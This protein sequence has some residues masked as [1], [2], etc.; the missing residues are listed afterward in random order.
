MGKYLLRSVWLFVYAMTKGEPPTWRNLSHYLSQSFAA[1]RMSAFSFFLL[2]ATRALLLV[3]LQ[4]LIIKD[5][6]VALHPLDYLLPVK[7]LHSSFSFLL[8]GGV[9]ELQVE[10]L[11]SSTQYYF[12]VG[13]ATKLCPYPDVVA[14]DNHNIKIG[15]VAV[16]SHTYK[17]EIFKMAFILSFIIAVI[18][19]AVVLMIVSRLNLGLSVANFTSAIIAALVIALV[20]AVVNWLLGALGIGFGGGLLGL[21]I[22]LI[23]AAIVLMVSDRFVAGMRVNGFGGA[24]IAAIAIAVVNWLVTLLLAQLGLVV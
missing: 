2:I 5:L 15:T 18:V 14:H 1:I 12:V 6:H 23:V 16:H 11:Y 8:P 20:N 10:V 3:R 19:A 7:R 22:N 17:K 21:I 24:I 4:Q 13:L 9:T